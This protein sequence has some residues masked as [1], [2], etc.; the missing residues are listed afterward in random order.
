MDEEVSGRPESLQDRD[1]VVHFCVD[2]PGRK[3]RSSR[4]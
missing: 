2:N 3:I 1:L 4:F